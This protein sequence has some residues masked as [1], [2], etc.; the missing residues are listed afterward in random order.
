VR[1]AAGAAAAAS[2]CRRYILGGGNNAAGCPDMWMLDLLRLGV[3]ALQWEC[4]CSFDGRSALASEGVS[5]VAAPAHG[6][7]V[8]FGGYNG[9][10]HNAVSVFRPSDA[11]PSLSASRALDAD[12]AASG[13]RCVRL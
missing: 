2:L 5:V 6:G 3:D 10:H 8:A 12:T 13:R 4:V 7:L 9:A 1:A 11:A